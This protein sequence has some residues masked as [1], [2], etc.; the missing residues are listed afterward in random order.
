M[1][2]RNS[3]KKVKLILFLRVYVEKV[4]GLKKRTLNTYRKD[5]ALIKCCSSAVVDEA[6]CSPHQEGFV[7]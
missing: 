6:R 7:R 4:D 5:V 2:T 3:L 1:K